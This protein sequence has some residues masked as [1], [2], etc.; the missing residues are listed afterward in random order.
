[1]SEQ[2]DDPCPKCV[3]FAR[4]A[5]IVEKNRNLFYDQIIKE[6]SIIRKY[7]NINENG[8]RMEW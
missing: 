8:E 1:M 2:V 6:C 7:L 5:A 3:L 4:C